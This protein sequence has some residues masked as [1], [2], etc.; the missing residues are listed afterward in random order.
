MNE[1]LREALGLLKDAPQVG[2]AGATLAGIAVT[3]WILAFTMVWAFVRMT[4]VLYEAYKV[5]NGGAD[6]TCK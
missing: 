4:L 6:G 5:I 1:H 3:N 2:V